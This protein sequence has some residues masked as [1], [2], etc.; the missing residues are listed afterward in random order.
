MEDAG[1]LSFQVAYALTRLWLPFVANYRTFLSN[2]VV[3][4]AELVTVAAAS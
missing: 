1:K 3:D 4:H 2:P